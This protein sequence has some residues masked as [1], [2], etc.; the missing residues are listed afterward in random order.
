MIKSHIIDGV[1]LTKFLYWI[2]KNQNKKISEIDAEKKLE[3]FRKQNKNYL[4]PSFSTISATGKNGSII[5]YRASNKTCREIKQ[6]DV[7][8]CDSG[9]QYT[10]G[11][12]DVT[13][14]IS[15]KVQ[16]KNIKDTFTRVLKGHIAVATA[17]ISKQKTGSN[18]DK[19]A[20][21]YLKEVKK[22]FSHGTGHGV[23]YFL[24]VHEGPQAIS[25]RNNI[26]LIEDAAHALGAKYKG[27]SIGKLRITI[28]PVDCLPIGRVCAVVDCQG[29]L[30]HSFSPRGFTA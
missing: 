30:W 9:G 23:G 22:D 5:H 28:C 20:R 12:T 29:A 21:K 4:F 2:K 8:L 18:I 1:A 6:N 26:I 14:T 7:Y 13:R 16:P 11:T 3:S 19:L 10:Y 24:N 15:F 17:N 27:K 25:K